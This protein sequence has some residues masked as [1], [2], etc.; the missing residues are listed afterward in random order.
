MCSYKE[1]SGNNE[2]NLS[3]MKHDTRIYALQKY[4][5]IFWVVTGKQNVNIII[6]Y[7]Y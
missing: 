3:N 7:K 4:K 1:V 2:Q 6:H 5:L